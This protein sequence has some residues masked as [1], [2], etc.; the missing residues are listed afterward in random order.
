LAGAIE[1]IHGVTS[2]AK[3]SHPVNWLKQKAKKKL[4]LLADA[5]ERIHGVTSEA[6]TS[7]P[8]NWLQQKTKSQTF[9]WRY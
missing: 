6:K 7:Q 1:R 4:K 2:E 3:T 8:V 5:I 9:G